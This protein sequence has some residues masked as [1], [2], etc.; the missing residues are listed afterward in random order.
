MYWSLLIHSPTKELRV[1]LSFGSYRKCRYKHLSGGFCVVQV[2]NSFG[3]KHP[4]SMIAG[5]YGKRRFSFV[6]N[7][8]TVFQNSW[9]HFVSPPA[10]MS[11]PLVP[12][13]VGIWWHQCSGFGHPNRC[14]VV[15]GFNLHFS[16]NTCCLL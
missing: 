15:S 12:L 2:F 14:V 5:S 7:H 3:V 4:M 6:R 11:V 16:D 13:L 10:C 8:R 1:L 9:D